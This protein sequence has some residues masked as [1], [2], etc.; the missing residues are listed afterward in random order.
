MDEEWRY[1]PGWGNKY[2]VF[3]SGEVKTEDR[4]LKTIYRNGRP[5]VRLTLKKKINIFSLGRLVLIAFKGP[6]KATNEIVKY[7]DNDME[8]N[9]IDNLC[10]GVR[11]KKVKF[12]KQ[13]RQLLHNY[14]RIPKHKDNKL[15]IDNKLFLNK[16]K[17]QQII[18]LYRDDRVSIADL[19]LDFVV[20]PLAIRYVLQEAN[21]EKQKDEEETS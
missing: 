13:E 7:I 21:P 1:I 18:E 3:K 11:S 2:R 16:E 14:A 4:T 8:N 12:K 19:A 10:W 17:Q 20:D 5:Y 9:H 6:P 15:R